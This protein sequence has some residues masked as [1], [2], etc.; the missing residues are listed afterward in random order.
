MARSIG[1]YT[2]FKLAEQHDKQYKAEYYAYLAVTQDIKKA[3]SGLLPKVGFEAKGGPIINKTKKPVTHQF[4]TTQLETPAYKTT[5]EGAIGAVEMTQAII[6]VKAL[7]DYGLARIIANAAHERYLSKRVDLMQAI[8]TDY[9]NVILAKNNIELAQSKINVLKQL[10]NDA[11][12]AY[13]HDEQSRFGLAESQL[14]LLEATT[15]KKSAQQVRYDARLKLEKSTGKLSQK[16]L[17]ICI[18]CRPFIQ[19]PSIELIGANQPYMS[20]H[21][22]LQAYLNMVA[23]KKNISAS[24]SERYPNLSLIARAGYIYLNAKRKYMLEDYNLRNRT[25]SYNLSTFKYAARLELSFPLY[26]GGAISADTNQSIDKYE[27]AENQLADISRALS[28]SIKSNKSAI[29]TYT[30]NIQQDKQR[31]MLAKQLLNMSKIKR[32]LNEG[33]MLDYLNVLDRYI[34]A[35]STL[36]KDY[37]NLIKQQIQLAKHQGILNDSLLKRLDRYYLKRSRYG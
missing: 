36:E 22:W 9:L 31:L 14:N 23:A 18:R 3:R 27:E 2:A 19:L 6:N 4:V 37:I 29:K 32:S 10:H 17:P 16:L 13:R 7:L 24:R 28:N 35:N 1:F 26:W 15:Q 30:A 8:T 33:S 12:I 11:K 20:S 25:L 34:A 21:L 5:G